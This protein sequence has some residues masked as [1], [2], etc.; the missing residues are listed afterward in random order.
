MPS[1]SRLEPEKP[2]A[3]GTAASLTEALPRPLRV[4]FTPETLLSFHLQGLDPPG[5]PGPSPDPILPCRWAANS[6]TAVGSEGLIPPSSRTRCSEEPRAR[7]LLALSP[8]RLSHSPPWS[9]PLGSSSHVLH[10][11]AAKPQ[12]T[13]HLRVSPDGEPVSHPTSSRGS[14]GG[15]GLSGVLPPRRSALRSPEPPGG[16]FPARQST[17]LDAPL[18]ANLGKRASLR[19]GSVSAAGPANLSEPDARIL[20]VER[21]RR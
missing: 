2:T 8:L 13:L 4:C 18:Q 10:A 6:A 7:A 20:T 1:A 11:R 5:D 17:K 16:S 15:T 9:R 12:R 21:R 14:S 19:R 3:I